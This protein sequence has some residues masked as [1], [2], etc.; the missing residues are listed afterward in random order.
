ML[1]PKQFTVLAEV[2]G[3]LATIA[4]TYQTIRLLKH[5]KSVRD[6]RKMANDLKSLKD[7]VESGKVAN[8]KD[9]EMLEKGAEELERT[10]AQWDKRDQYLVFIG[11]GGLMLSFGIKLL[12]LYLEP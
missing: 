9:I 3:F 1:T 2:I 5:Q 12:G 10:V 4:L 7:K 8:Q 11:L 6:M